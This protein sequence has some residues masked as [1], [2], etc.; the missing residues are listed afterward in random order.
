MTTRT[1]PLHHPSPASGACAAWC[2]GSASRPPDISL[3]LISTCCRA[4][5]ER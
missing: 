4:H 2:A 5:L 3:P 1:S